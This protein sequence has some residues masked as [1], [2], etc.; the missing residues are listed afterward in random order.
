MLAKHETL[1]KEIAYGSTGQSDQ[2]RRLIVTSHRVLF[3]EEDFSKKTFHMKAVKRES[4]SGFD[5]KTERSTRKS[6][7]LIG[8]LVLVFIAFLITRAVFQ[9]SDWLF[10]FGFAI[11]RVEVQVMFG[12]VIALFLVCAAVLGYYYVTDVR[13]SYTLRL[14]LHEKLHN[15]LTFQGT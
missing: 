14:Y 5:L 10:F 1:E 12:F 13:E 3:V 15:A 4:I 8:I 7:H 6:K 9:Q 11:D 2:K